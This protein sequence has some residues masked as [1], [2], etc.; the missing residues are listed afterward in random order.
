MNNP[1]PNIQDTPTCHAGLTTAHLTSAALA[2]VDKTQLLTSYIRSQNTYRSYF[3]HEGKKAQAAWGRPDANE[4]DAGDEKPNAVE[5]AEDVGAFGTPELKPRVPEPMRRTR[6]QDE[7][8]DGKACEDELSE[9]REEAS[10]EVAPHSKKTMYKEKRGETKV[11]KDSGVV[12]S[13]SP[14][15]INKYLV[16]KGAQA[17]RQSR[18]RERSRD[19]EREERASILYT[20]LPG[21]AMAPEPLVV[22]SGRR[23]RRRARKAI[24]D[25]KSVEE[26]EEDGEELRTHR[27]TNRGDK[28]SKS[29]SK[30]NK[31]TALA[32]G[33]ALMHGFSASNV[34]PGRLTVRA[35]SHC[36]MEEVLT[37]V[38]VETVV[39]CVP[40]G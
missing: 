8:N 1:P 11:T 31:T 23:E 29:K 25:P 16:T 14:N 38:V 34:G 2:K 4:E 10:S 9:D 26:E 5:D 3:V 24:V 7:D 18:K 20:C 22:L 36:S 28:G 40:E 32:E 27:A 37:G 19:H 39:W 15:K 35:R 12:R 21:Y 17:M 6:R 30:K 33:L 13:R